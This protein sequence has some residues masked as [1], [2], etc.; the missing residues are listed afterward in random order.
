MRK[1]FTLVELLIVTGLITMLVAMACPVVQKAKAAANATACLSNLRQMGNAL[2]MYVAENR[3]RMIDY[4]WS[5]AGDPDIAWRGYWPGILASYRVSG[6]AVLCPAADKPASYNHGMGYGSAT[7]AWTGN[8]QKN[9]TVVR[10]NSVNYR[11]SSYGFNRYLA[12]GEFDS[13]GRVTKLSAI[14]CAGYVPA[15]MDMVWLDA[16]P[17]NGSATE[18]PESP[19]DFNGGRL[20]SGDP[21]HWRFLI[22]RHGKA[23]NVGMA[24]GSARTVP[25]EETYSLIWCQQ[26][27][28]YRLPLGM[29]RARG[30]GG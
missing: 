1:G 25:L 12:A 5:S 10:F 17:G 3:G 7:D 2:T 16:R 6:D 15:F 27:I 8:Y 29:A 26:W 18:H 28:R 30:N 13:D 11:I 21:E 19:P 20:K 23:I 22:S 14:K 24:D 9:G 4:I